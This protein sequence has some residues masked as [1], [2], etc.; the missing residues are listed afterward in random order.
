[1]LLFYVYRDLHAEMV[2]PMLKMSNVERYLDARHKKLDKKAI[3]LYN[4]HY[5]NFIRICSSERGTH[6]K[7]EIRA[8]MKLHVVYVVDLLLSPEGIILE[9]QCECAAGM[10]PHAHCKHVCCILFGL[11]DFGE[12]KSFKTLATCTQQLQTFHQAKKHLGSPVKAEKLK[13]QVS[14]NIDL[15]PRPEEFRAVVSYPDFFRNTLVNHGVFSNAAIMH[16]VQPANPYAIANDHDCLEMSPAD[17]YLDSSG[18]VSL[19]A[20]QRKAIE[21]ATRLNKKL[22][23]MERQKRLCSSAFGKVCKL[24]ER[25]DKGKLAKFFVSP[26]HFSC[27]ATNHGITYEDVAVGKYEQTTGCSTQVCGLLVSEE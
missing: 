9:C 2:V 4:E 1:M 18:I 8:E 14:E 7:A 21:E 27:A 10:G 25:A 24:T 19:S 5:V 16:T 26:K 20:E 17:R 6:F 12:S 13:L 23:H 15:D 22:W 11:T 3:R